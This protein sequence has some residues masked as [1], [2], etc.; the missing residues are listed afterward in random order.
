MVPRRAQVAMVEPERAPMMTPIIDGQD[1]E[2]APDLAQPFIQ[3][4]DRV[5]PQAGMED[6]F[7]H[8]DEERVR[9]AG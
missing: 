9:G 3:H 5:Q 1:R 4:V 6:Q 7:P 8:E 2:P